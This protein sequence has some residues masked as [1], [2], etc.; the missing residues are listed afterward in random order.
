MS[1][2]YNWTIT[3]DHIDGSETGL[4][5]PANKSR[6]TANEAHFRMFDDDEELYYEGTIW[7]GYD[8]FIV[9]YPETA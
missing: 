3:R 1:S 6:H 7:G 2:I 5:G 9:E 8:G 4:T